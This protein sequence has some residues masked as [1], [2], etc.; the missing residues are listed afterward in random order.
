MTSSTHKTF[1]GPQGGLIILKND[2]LGIYEKSIKTQVFPGIL[3]NHHLHRIPALLAAAI[4]LDTEL[5]DYAKRVVSNA[6]AFAEALYNEGF[7]VCAADY[8]F[9]ETHQ[10]V[11][12]VSKLGGGAKVANELEKNGIICN[13]NSLPWD[14]SVVKPSGIRLGVQEMTLKGWTKDDFIELAK[15]FKKILI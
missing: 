5:T 11:V 1:P 6:K 2:E 4:I 15:K 7:D 3:S 8:G 10:V 12:D 14:K 9:T 13:K